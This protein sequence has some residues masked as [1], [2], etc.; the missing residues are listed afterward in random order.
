MRPIKVNNKLVCKLP[1]RLNRKQLIDWLSEICPTS[2][3]HE[4][5]YLRVKSNILKEDMVDIFVLS[6]TP[7]A[8]EVM[9]K[10]YIIDK[11]NITVT[12]W[13]RGMLNL[14]YKRC[15]LDSIL[16]LG[17]RTLSR[18]WNLESIVHNHNDSHRSFTVNWR[19]ALEIA[20]AVLLKTKSKETADL[21]E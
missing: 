9:E 14:L 13:H 6:Q 12:V 17:S 15:C 2:W 1:K 7:H 10:K 18:F 3:T 21:N 19:I 4:Y 5:N 11:N 16:Y 20:L 8:I